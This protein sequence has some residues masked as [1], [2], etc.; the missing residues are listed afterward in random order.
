ME[1]NSSFSDESF[2]SGWG[3]GS[4]LRRLLNKL[5]ENKECLQ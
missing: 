2:S 3:K 1:D 5:Q 4:L